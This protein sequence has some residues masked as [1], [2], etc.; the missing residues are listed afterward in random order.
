MFLQCLQYV[1][2]ELL[3]LTYGALP[4]PVTCCFVVLLM[5]MLLCFV[6]LLHP[7]YNQAYCY[8]RFMLLFIL[9]CCCLPPGIAAH[10][11]VVLF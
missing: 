3:L 5:I 11:C 9:S 8:A 6:S 2:S 1:Y 10:L 7:V 4:R